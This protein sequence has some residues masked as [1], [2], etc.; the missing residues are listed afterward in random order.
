MTDY[1]P[2]LYFVRTGCGVELWEWEGRWEVYGIE[3]I[4]MLPLSVLSGPHAADE[5]LSAVRETGHRRVPTG[6]T[7]DGVTLYEDP[8]MTDAAKGA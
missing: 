6:M 8:D 2:G 3:G 5:L 4:R 7:L 1:K